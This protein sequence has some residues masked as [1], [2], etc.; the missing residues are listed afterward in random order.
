LFTSLADKLLLGTD[1]ILVIKDR[2]LIQNNPE[3]TFLSS[4]GT[5][6]KTKT[7]TNKIA[8]INTSVK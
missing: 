8:T 3:K 2:K 6:N 7:K 5:P 4:S 1:P